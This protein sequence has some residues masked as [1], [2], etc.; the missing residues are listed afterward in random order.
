GGGG[1]ARGGGGPWG[2]PGGGGESGDA[3]RVGPHLAR[4][5]GGAQ[6]EVAAALVERR[7]A[8]LRQPDRRAVGYR[9][10]LDVAGAELDLRRTAVDQRPAAAHDGARAVAGIELCRFNGGLERRAREAAALVG[11]VEAEQQQRHG[12]RPER[13][14]ERVRQRFDARRRKGVE[15]LQR[16][17]LL[18]DT[19]EDELAC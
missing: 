16:I 8:G 4:R 7:E 2:A 10:L 5:H 15:L 1:G 17:A 13:R 11:R 6:A 14:V 3:R 18:A 9:G 12:A 19:T